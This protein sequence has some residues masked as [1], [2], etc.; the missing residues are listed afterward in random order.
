MA[1]IS[2]HLVLLMQLWVSEV[3]L[4]IEAKFGWP[5]L[6]SRICL[7]SA[8]RMSGDWRSGMALVCSTGLSFCSQLTW[9]CSPGELR[10]ESKGKHSGPEGIGWTW[11]AFTVCILLAEADHKDDW[12]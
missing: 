1:C 10:S 2:R 12:I 5:R 8:S 7:W 6:G 11:Q 3:V 9:D 4:L